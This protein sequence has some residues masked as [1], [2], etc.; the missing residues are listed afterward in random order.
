MP[1]LRPN[2]LSSGDALFLYLEREG[3]PLSIAA[4]CAF[5]GSIALEPFT[6]YIESKLPLIPR[7]LQRIVW[8]P[9][10]IGLPTWEFDPDFDVRN[11]VCEMTLKHG[12][13]AEFKAVVGEILSVNLRRDRPLWDLTLVH[14]LKGKRTGLVI[15]L[16][17]CLADGISGV[18][19]MNTILDPSPVA[20]P[21]PKHKERFQAPPLH[22]PSLTE[23][24]VNA[25][26]TSVERALVIETD[27]M[28]MARTVIANQLRPPAPDPQ[29][30]PTQ[31]GD[32][33]I[34][35][36]DDF[37]RMIYEFASPTD[38][39]P[40]N[41]VCQGPQLF[42]WAEI[43]LE[44]MKA[45]K[46][47]C[48]ATINDIVLAVFASAVRRYAELHG[49]NLEGRVVRVVVPVNLR[50]NLEVTDLGNRITFLAVNIPLDIPDMRE[51]VDAVRVAVARAR[52]ARVAEVISLLGTTIET[53]PTPL[54]AMLLPV[55]SAL[56][57]NV[58]NTICTNVPGPK[59][60]LYLL[61]H[62]V[63]SCYPYVPIGGEMG[64]NCAVLSYHDKVFFGFSGDAGAIPDLELLDKFLTASFAELTEAT[65]A[66]TSSKKAARPKAKAEPNP[67]SKVEPK[68]K[69]KPKPKPKAKAK[70]T[71]KRMRASAKAHSVGT[72]NEASTGPVTKE[73]Q[74][75]V[76]QTKAPLPEKTHKTV[77]EKMTFEAEKTAPA[78]EKT[79]SDQVVPLKAEA[80][81][82]AA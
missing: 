21:I 46:N 28:E 56:P 63:L 8:P 61:G 80:A 5:E 53:I 33:A 44:E 27:L 32:M 73:T 37:T 74:V 30:E 17:H 49:Q 14:G 57:L 24:L 72:A 79:S 65:R 1:D 77:A 15:R 71:P 6:N 7:Y 47:A 38:R 81:S 70:A 51:L 18:G 39:L 54:Q 10:D 35:P 42:N 45:V 62:K 69:R 60:P 4:T 20:P 82:P 58:C 34:S 40:F 41:V 31:D 76:R 9:F 2:P 26:L 16:H 11:H 59:V 29:A 55:L 68:R 22:T 75:P 25:F 13:E 19:I 64:M 23:S 66:V 50:P 52:K 67:E 48:D 36:I 12:T 43:S 78:A 3:A